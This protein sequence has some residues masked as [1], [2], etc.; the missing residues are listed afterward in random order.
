[1]F[2]GEL[3]SVD[4]SDS[5]AVSNLASNHLLQISA[6]WSQ[7]QTILDEKDTALKERLNVDNL[8]SKQAIQSLAVISVT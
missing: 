6:L 2:A 4:C 1:V 7:Q 3:A 8:S 5:E